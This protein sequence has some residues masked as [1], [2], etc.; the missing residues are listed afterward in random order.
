MKKLKETL[1]YIS[2]ELVGASAMLDSEWNDV[3]NGHKTFE[4]TPFINTSRLLCQ[5]LVS[6]DKARELLEEID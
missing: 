3:L 4:S 1:Q 5:A 2:G 6:V